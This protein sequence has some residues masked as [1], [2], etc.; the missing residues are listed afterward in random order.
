MGSVG[1]LPDRYSAG[2][3]SAGVTIVGS[4]NMDIV[5]AVD[6]IPQPGETLLAESAARY[7]GGKGL[8]Q[9][10]A[11]ARA[12]ARTTFVGAVGSDDNGAALTATMVNADID[13][14]FL[15]PSAAETGQAFIVVDGAG[16]N[17][18]IVAS[19]AN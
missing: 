16:E 6:R 13:T 4:A 9:A 14:E 19:G 15:R 10:V 12:N 8:N 18:I 7:P 5:F 11:A 3:A 2:M 17:T 1:N